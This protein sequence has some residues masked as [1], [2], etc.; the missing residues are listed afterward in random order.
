MV[1]IQDGQ[2]FKNLQFQHE[3]CVTIFNFLKLNFSLTTGKELIWIQIR[4]KF[5]E[6]GGAGHPW[7]LQTDLRNLLIRIMASKLILSQ[8]PRVT[9]SV[10]TPTPAISKKIF[11]FLIHQMPSKNLNTIINFI[12]VHKLF[13]KK[14]SFIEV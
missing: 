8:S 14:C 6:G 4:I 1:N 5:M 3:V 10:T 13:I 12:I 2:I 11:G 7:A 9:S